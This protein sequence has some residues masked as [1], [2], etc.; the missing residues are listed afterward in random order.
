V[1][2]CTHWAGDQEVLDNLFALVE[3]LTGRAWK[4]RDAMEVF[5]QW[6]TFT[7]QCGAE[8]EGKS[9]VAVV[10]LLI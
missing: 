1:L 3:L 10:R 5:V 4:F 8:R 7:V 6:C 9:V 2:S